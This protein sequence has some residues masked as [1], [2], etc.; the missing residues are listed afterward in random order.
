MSYSV[1]PNDLRYILDAPNE[2]EQFR[3]INEIME[4]YPRY[5]LWISAYHTAAEEAGDPAGFAE[6]YAGVMESAVA[7]QQRRQKRVAH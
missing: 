2:N 5:G 4:K 7:D 1:D 3:R 6:F